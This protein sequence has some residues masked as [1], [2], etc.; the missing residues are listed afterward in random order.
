MRVTVIAVG[1]LKERFWSDA[2][3]EYL[4]R[5][6]P[7]ARVDVIEV[8]DRDV[9]ADEARAVETEGAAILRAIPEGA[10]VALLDIGGRAR[11][12]EEFA[13]WLEALG[14]AGLPHVA[15]VIGGAAGVHPDVRARAHERVS[16]GAL[17]LPHQLARVVLLEQVYRAFRIMRGEPYHR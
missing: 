4:K 13:G 5:L 17:T 6:T 11:S 9:T 15:F 8:P 7:Y 2:A 12:S 14:S 1:K 16:L 10:T 3:A